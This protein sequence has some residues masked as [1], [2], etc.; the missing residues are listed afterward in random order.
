MSSQAASRTVPIREA[1]FPLNGWRTVI[2]G[3]SGVVLNLAAGGRPSNTLRLTLAGEMES[4]ARL[5]WECG[6]SSGMFDLRYGHCFQMFESH[7]RGELAPAG[8][9]R[10][11]QECGSDAVEIFADERMEPAAF[12]LQ[13]VDDR[14]AGDIHGALRNLD[15]LASLQPFGWMEGCVLDGLTDLAGRGLVGSGLGE[16]LDFWFDG[17]GFRYLGPTGLLEENFIFGIEAVLPFAALAKH[18]P[19]DPSLEVAKAYLAGHVGEDGLILDRDQDAEGR[20]G[21]PTYLS[22]EGCYT[23]AYPLA[24]FSRVFDD[25]SWGRLALTQLE[26]RIRDLVI[27]GAAC[28]RRRLHG[29][30][31][32]HGWARAQVWWLLGISRTLRELPERQWSSFLVRSLKTGAKTVLGHQREDGLW[33][34]YLPEDGTG[35]DVS[36]SAGIAAALAIGN[37]IGILDHDCLLGAQ[38]CAAGLRKH[39]RVDGFLGSVAQINR[40]GD[41]LQRGGYR[42]LAQFALGLWG[43]LHAALPD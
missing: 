22:A 43:Q 41:S 6:A 32:Q 11:W 33:N 24:V 23:L 10:I 31:E 40:G 25:D 14:G 17:G 42:V 1:S 16:H 29:T 27:D 28:Q 7:A 5:R 18:R 19:R 13:A 39:F 30:L 4:T 35:V 20:A 21:G 26:A 38:R 2:P 8:G 37:E 3:E 9:I 36:G 12:R 34:V 15:S